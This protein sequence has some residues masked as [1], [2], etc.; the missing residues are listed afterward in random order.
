MTYR[1]SYYLGKVAFRLPTP[2]MNAM[3]PHSCASM[4]AWLSCS[5]QLGLPCRSRATMC[6]FSLPAV[7]FMRRCVPTLVRLFPLSEVLAPRLPTCCHQVSRC[8]ALPSHMSSVDWVR[9]LFPQSFV[10]LPL[11]TPLVTLE[12]SRVFT[13]R[14]KS[15]VGFG[16]LGSSKISL[17]PSSSLSPCRLK[18]HF[19]SVSFFVS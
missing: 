13:S 6:I 9:M 4:L 11:V 18:Q 7:L 14:H 3:C 5:G 8:R 12:P 15:L 2:S 10:S 19:S 17:K 1:F 16:R